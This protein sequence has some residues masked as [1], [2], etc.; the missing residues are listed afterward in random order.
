MEEV[1]EPAVL[2]LLTGKGFHRTLLLSRTAAFD[3]DNKQFVDAPDDAIVC[4]FNGSA[5]GF[6]D[7]EEVAAALR[8]GN[9]APKCVTV[10]AAT[11]AHVDVEAPAFSPLAAPYKIVLRKCAFS[12]EAAAESSGVRLPLHIRYA[13]PIAQSDTQRQTVEGPFARV[14]LGALCDA[15][16]GCC[17]SLNTSVPTGRGHLAPQ[18]MATVALAYLLAAWFLVLKMRSVLGAAQATGKRT[19]ETQ[20]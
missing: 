3:N 8:A 17:V 2:P 7:V 14:S 6:V 5:D 18:L 19:S 9:I 20:K 16:G 12:E 13:A 1:T 10:H 15:T 11:H 4:T